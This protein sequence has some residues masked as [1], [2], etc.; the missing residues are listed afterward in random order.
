MRTAD[1]YISR[2]QRS[3]AAGDLADVYDAWRK[4]LEH[5]RLMTRG[6]IAVR[7]HTRCKPLILEAVEAA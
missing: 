5:E 1:E 2:I 7:V 3:H 4:C 6:T